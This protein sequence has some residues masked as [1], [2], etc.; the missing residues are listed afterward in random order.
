[1]AGGARVSPRRLL[2]PCSWVCVPMD[3]VQSF[4][5]SGRFL[6][7]TYASGPVGR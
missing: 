6:Q 4:G 3:D 2:A 7:L 1:M 5:S